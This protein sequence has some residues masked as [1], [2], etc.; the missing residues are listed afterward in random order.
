MGHRRGTGGAVIGGMRRELL[1]ILGAL[2]AASVAC[3]GRAE[4]GVDLGLQPLNASCAATDAD[5]PAGGWICGES[6]TVECA[7]PSGTDVGD[8]YVVESQ[9]APGSML[10]GGGDAVEI[11][12][13]GPYDPGTHDLVLT[14]VDAAGTRTELCSS[15][16][17]VQ[18]TLP[19]E[20]QLR[21]V[22]LWPPNHK[23]RTVTPADCVEVQ[24][25]CDDDLDV[26]FMWASS[27][28][29]EDGLGDGH[30]APD[31]VELT[32]DSVQLRAERSG[33]ENGR[34]YK[35][36]FRVTD[37]AGN[38][39]EGVCVV[40]VVHDQ[41]GAAAVDDGEDHRVSLA[42]DACGGSSNGGGG[43]GGSGSGGGGSGG[44]GTGSPVPP[45]GL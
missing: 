38:Q 28:E 29:P 24:D 34:V 32:C 1:L 10:C 44:S 3:G 33:N 4:D 39:S 18:D 8:I 22:Q 25:R 27:D 16:L 42:A 13:A 30:H 17:T 12:D 2:A 20:V 26:V 15:E 6:R 36:G 21:E 43:S 7:G 37:D 45:G 5:V 19:P 23:Y 35:L 31:I 14:R 40:Q 9:V 11:N 41:R